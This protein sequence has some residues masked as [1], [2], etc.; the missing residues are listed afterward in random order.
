M[1]EKSMA[2]N[3]NTVHLTFVQIN[4]TWALEIS[5]KSVRRGAFDLSPKL[6]KVIEKYVINWNITKQISMAIVWQ[7]HK[8]AFK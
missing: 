7:V 3:L 8:T 4:H 2:I 5:K 1:Y 6:M